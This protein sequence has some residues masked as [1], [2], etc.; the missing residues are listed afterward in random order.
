MSA[1]PPEQG[2]VVRVFLPT[3]RRRHLLPRAIASLRA[4]TFTSWV[5]EVHNDDPADGFPGELLSTLG[6]SRLRLVQHERNLGPIATFNLFYRQT[7]EPFASILED[8]NT[9]EPEFLSTLVATLKAHPATTLVWCNQQVEAEQP[10]GSCRAT[11]R[12]VNPVESGDARPKIINWGHPR[13]MMGALHAN[14]AMLLRSCAGQSFETPVIPFGAVE[15]FRERMLPSP[16]IYLS[17]PLASFT[18]TQQTARAGDRK[19]WGAMQVTL[20]ATFL[21]HA[22]LNT[23][24]AAAL[25]KHYAEQTPSMTNQVIAAGLIC[26]EARPMLRQATLHQWL[27]FALSCLRHPSAWWNTLRVRRRHPDWWDILNAETAARFAER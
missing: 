14:G 18:V 27:R 7:V 15:A 3:F 20:A 19:D 22:Q 10:D 11:G 2:A 4:Q 8:D 1:L 24:E 12:W 16:L 17:Q 21:R 23:A 6:D 9:W 5:C 13:Q 25:W 26:R